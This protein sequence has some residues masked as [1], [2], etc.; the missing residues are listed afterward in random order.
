[1]LI[2]KLDF[3]IYAD[4]HQFYLECESSPHRSDEVWDSAN[5]ASDRM[6]GVSEKLIAIGTARYETVPV[7]IEFHDC[8]P[9]LE[10]DK[11]SR[12]NETGLEVTSNKLVLSGCTEYLPDAARISV[13]PATYAVRVLYGNLETVKNDFEGEDFYILQLWKADSFQE[14]KTLKP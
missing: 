6:L 2:R 1:M 14:V 11:Y 13:E 5:I 8:E 12:V 3:E 10:L 7:S 4:Y 9:V